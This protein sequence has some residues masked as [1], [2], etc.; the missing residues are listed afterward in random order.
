MIYLQTVTL[1]GLHFKRKGKG[2]GYVAPLPFTP[3]DGAYRPVWDADTST[4]SYLVPQPD[5]DDEPQDS[6]TMEVV[7]TEEEIEAGITYVTTPKPPSVPAEVSPSQF[8]RALTQL[9]LRDSV[10]AAVAGA[11]QDTKD[12]WEFAIFVARTDPAVNAI[13]AALGL[14]AEQIDEV[15]ILAITL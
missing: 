15:F 2:G 4:L 10:E 9:G 7:I 13:G 3:E 14:T 1:S 6:I 11:D 12:H 5:V 8:R